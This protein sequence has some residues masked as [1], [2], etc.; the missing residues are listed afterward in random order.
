MILLKKNVSKKK[1]K[2]FL[3]LFL[4]AVM[5]FSM[6]G[7]SIFDFTYLFTNFSAGQGTEEEFK[8]FVEDFAFETAQ[9]SYMTTH[10]MMENPEDFG[11][12]K[13]ECP[14]EISQHFDENSWDET[15]ASIRELQTELNRYNPD[16]LSAEMRNIYYYLE[17]Y[18][19]SSLR[20]NQDKF[21]YYGCAFEQVS[22]IHSQL[23]SILGEWD[24]RCEQDIKD[25]IEIMKDIPSYIDSLL[26]YT[27]T[28]VERGEWVGDIQGIIDSCQEV[29]DNGENSSMLKGMLNNIQK[30]EL[31]DK[32][33]KE[34]TD[35]ITQTY[36]D[37]I[38]PSYQSIIDAMN[39]IDAD[40]QVQ[41][42]MAELEYG[43]EYYEALFYSKTS[44]DKEI[45][46]VLEEIDDMR[47]QIL[48]EL[49]SVIY[50]NPQL[51]D[52]IGED[53]TTDFTSYEEII[54]FLSEK[55]YNDFP[56]IDFPRYEAEPLEKDMEVDGISAYF[57]IPPLDHSSP[58]KIRVNTGMG[59]NISSVSTFT[60]LAHEGVP[61]HM[62]QT[63]YVYENFSPWTN[64][65][66]DFIGYTEGYA[67]YVELYSLQYLK[68]T[69]GISQND[70]NFLRLYNMYNYLTVA[71]LDIQVNYYGMRL[72]DMAMELGY[73]QSDLESIE[74]LY[75]QLIYNPGVF[76]P[77]Y[78][79]FM[80]IYQLRTEAEQA[81]GNAFNDKD[82]HE[83]L[84]QS[85]SV[86]FNAVERNV[87]DYISK[88]NKMSA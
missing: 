12:D 26:V 65:I 16:N 8:Q 17:F 80:E 35:E 86:S 66:C 84:L 29:V 23:P 40:S 87:R 11:I 21:R 67:T 7:C 28:Q 32:K 52:T 41:G 51:I 22:G 33:L 3:A 2:G 88:Y 24:F 72:E 37:Y 47:S 81:L 4:C 75:E 15:T 44:A 27:S 60:T 36:K 6:S 59:S 64:I 30:V 38:I 18:A 77:Y 46:Q 62:Y 70:L 58:M 53:I 13:S 56:E 79:G 10:I 73:S 49:Q 31:T 83:V 19:D 55:Y 25:I 1:F 71:Y 69:E 48:Y 43:K 82:F 57:V 76:L 20:L 61:G 68:D 50:S 54:D 42:S 14:L 39:S 78:I 5:T 63:A 45:G 74:P 9:S 85:G 34:Y